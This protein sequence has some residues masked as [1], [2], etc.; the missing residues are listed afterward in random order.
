MTDT[1][2]NATTQSNREIYDESQQLPSVINNFLM[3]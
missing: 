2:F 3:I 1:M